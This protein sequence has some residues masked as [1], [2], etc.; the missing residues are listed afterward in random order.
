MF[1]FGAQNVSPAWPTFAKARASVEIAWPI[2]LN[3]VA[4]KEP[5]VVQTCGNDVATGV[6]D[7]NVVPGENA[8]PCSAWKD[9][10]DEGASEKE[11]EC[12]RER[13]RARSG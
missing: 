8:T 6:G 12:E 10:K 3:S 11:R 9:G 7:E 2:R 4:L 1:T 5:A 13:E